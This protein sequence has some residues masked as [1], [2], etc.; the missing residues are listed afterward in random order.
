MKRTRNRVTRATAFHF[1]DNSAR[2][3]ILANFL[4]ITLLTSV[5]FSTQDSILTQ[6]QWV[7]RRTIKMAPNASV[8]IK[9]NTL[10]HVWNTL[11]AKSP[12]L[13]RLQGMVG[14]ATFGVLFSRAIGAGLTGKTNF[15][16]VSLSSNHKA[17]LLP[18]TTRHPTTRT[19]KQRLLCKRRSKLLWLWYVSFDAVFFF[20]NRPQYF[21]YFS[22]SFA[23]P[24]ELVQLSHTYS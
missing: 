7:A 14:K 6:Y 17:R 12:R 19:T 4:L 1:F 15:P 18:L 13:R 11:K 10:A 5:P 24:Q 16:R 20:L 23:E 21:S 9:G 22:F 2:E 8:A 3:L